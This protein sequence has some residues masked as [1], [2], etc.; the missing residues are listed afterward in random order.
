MSHKYTQYAVTALE[1]KY[2][3]YV[4]VRACVCVCVIIVFPRKRHIFS[5]S[6]CQ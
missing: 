5:G 1:L 4:C 6:I 3:I 2:I